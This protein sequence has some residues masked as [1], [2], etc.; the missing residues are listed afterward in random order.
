MR[1]RLAK[2]T[3]QKE[4]LRGKLVDGEPP[5]EPFTYSYHILKRS[6]DHELQKSIL[7]EQER[8]TKLFQ[9]LYNDMYD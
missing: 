6:E 1:H 4:I 7:Y 9:K 3:M 8:A 2:I 5:A